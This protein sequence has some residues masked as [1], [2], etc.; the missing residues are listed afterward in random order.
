MAADGERTTVPDGI[1][2]AHIEEP[3]GW[4]DHASPISLIV[5]AAV[6]AVGASGL[7]GSRSV[8]RAAEGPAARMTMASP[9]IIRNGEIYEARI[10]VEAR[11]PIGKLAIGITPALWRETTV[12]SMVPA[13]ADETQA[14][15]L[16]R[17]AY[18]P[19]GRGDRF[20]V[21]IS[22]QVNPTLGGTNEGRVV[23]LDGEKPLVELQ[24][25]VRILP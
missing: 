12:N 20:E 25:S 15:G 2:A 18:G 13:A 7:A 14:D 9:E 19:L 23:L 6:V 16:F 4:R 17:F 22:L 24:R 8:E 10:A 5:L 21:K 3:R 11:Q 1:E